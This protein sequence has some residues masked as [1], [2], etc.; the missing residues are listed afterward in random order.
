MSRV[1]LSFIVLAVAMTAAVLTS[2]GSQPT[3][4]VVDPNAGKHEITVT[5]HH[6]K[7]IGDCEPAAGNAGEFRYEVRV[8]TLGSG[9][10]LW[11]SPGNLTGLVGATQQPTRHTFSFIKDPQP[12]QGFEFETRGTEF[13]NG[14]ADTRMNE[15]GTTRT[16][17][18]SSGTNWDNGL[19]IIR[20]GDGECG[21]EVEYSVSVRVL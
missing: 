14:V 4:P 21:Y 9:D 13:E 17:M 19:K 7:I 11:L 3:K 10:T 12:G 18:Y 20:L 15:R 16:H 2:C 5:V 8:L 1:R 6:F